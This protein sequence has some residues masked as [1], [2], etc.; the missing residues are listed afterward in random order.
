[1]KTGCRKSFFTPCY[2]SVQPGF[3]LV[4]K[5]ALKGPPVTLQ[6]KKLSAK[7]LEIAV[8]PLRFGTELRRVISAPSR[9]GFSTSQNLLK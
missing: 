3:H 1:M 6:H 9:V 5:H 7:S 2:F 8:Q 4:R